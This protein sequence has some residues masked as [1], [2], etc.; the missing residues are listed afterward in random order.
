MKAE[1]LLELGEELGNYVWEELKKLVS[2]HHRQQSSKGDQ[3]SKLRSND[4][5]FQASSANRRKNCNEVDDS[6]KVLVEIQH[7]LEHSQQ[8]ESNELSQRVQ[9]FFQNID[10]E[11]KKW[12]DLSWFKEEKVRTMK[13][14]TRFLV[15]QA[16]ARKQLTQYK[17]Y[18][19]YQKHVIVC[20]AQKHLNS[21]G[22]FDSEDVVKNLWTYCAEFAVELTTRGKAVHIISGI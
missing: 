12:H 15:K 10:K 14:R 20:N 3:A 11:E 2:D 13:G 6:A 7:T 22:E 18:K 1:L 21:L 19:K 16:L 8:S 9:N 4:V 17:I 5:W